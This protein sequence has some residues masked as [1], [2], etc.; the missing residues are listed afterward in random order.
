MAS[1]SRIFYRKD[2]PGV[3]LE[4]NGITVAEY[5]NTQELVEAHIKGILARD[6][7]DTDKI[8]ALL[9]IYQSEKL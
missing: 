7:E 5:K 3:V 1:Q 9:E 6:H 8:R 4:R 2:P